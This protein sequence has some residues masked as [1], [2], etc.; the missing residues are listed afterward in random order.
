MIASFLGS[1]LFTNYSFL[2]TCNYLSSASAFQNLPSSLKENSNR[3]KKRKNLN[4]K[5]GYDAN[6]FKAVSG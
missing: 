3:F 2:K 6:Q 1:L 5:Y 4:I